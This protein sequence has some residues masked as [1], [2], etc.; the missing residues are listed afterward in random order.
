[1]WDELL[2]LLQPVRAPFAD[3]VFNALNLVAGCIVLVV[4]IIE[5]A[6]FIIVI[7]I[8]ISCLYSML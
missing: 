5:T 8:I 3:V 6:T 1:M 4:T 7:I 2:P